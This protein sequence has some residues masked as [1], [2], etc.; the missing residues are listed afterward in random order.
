MGYTAEGYQDFSVSLVA[1]FL[2]KHKQV[3]ST[4]LYSL[5]WIAEVIEKCYHSLPFTEFQENGDN[6]Y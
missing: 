5:D 6:N 2:I 4:F 1:I 3:M